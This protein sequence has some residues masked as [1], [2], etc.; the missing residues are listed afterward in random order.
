VVLC[1]VCLRHVSCVPNVPNVSRLFVF[2]MCLVYPMFPMSLGCL[3]SHWVYKTHDED[4][5]PR[6]IGNIGYIRHM[7]KTNNLETLGTL[8]TLDTCIFMCC[9]MVLCFVCL[10]RVSCV[11]NVANVSRLSIFMCCAMVLCFVC[12]RHVSVHK[13]HDEDKQPRDIGNIG[14]TRHMTKTNKTQNHNTTH[15]NGRLVYPKFPMSL[16]CLSSSCVLCSQ[17]CQCL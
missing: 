4:K 2:V 12:L 15:K 14:Y 6:D 9:V 16:G 17:C 8:G 5:Q 7:T 10:R 3:S 13:T 11:P 1:F